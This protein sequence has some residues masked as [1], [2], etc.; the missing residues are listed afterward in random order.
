MNINITRSRLYKI[1]QFGLLFAIFG[2]LLWSQPWKATTIQKTR[3]ISVTGQATV[4]AVPDEFA[5]YP[6]FEATGTNDPNT[7]EQLLASANTV[8]EDLMALGVPSDDITLNA[9]SLDRLYVEE[10]QQG[11][12]RVSLEIKVSDREMAQTVQD[13]LVSKDA[14]GQIS[15][16]A[17]FSD[18]KQKELETE[19][20]VKASE[21][22]RTKADAK[23]TLFNAKIGD[24]ITIGDDQ[25]V[26]FGAIEPYFQ[27][28]DLDSREAV[29]PI[30]PGEDEY[31]LTINVTYELQ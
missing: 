13:Y 21:D 16:Q 18:S 28:A 20:T 27:T 22:A 11:V 12:I 3:T 10:D 24:V 29:L 19:A 7:K 9:N 8:V 15:P 17:T 26:S 5:F 4:E 2:L 6:Y 25:A 31:S 23:A 30:L 1:V 14:K